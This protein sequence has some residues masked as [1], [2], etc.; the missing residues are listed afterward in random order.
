[1][2]SRIERALV[3]PHRV[4]RNLFEALCDAVAVRGLERQDLENQHVESALRNGEAR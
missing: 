2:E 3:D 4:A 1:M